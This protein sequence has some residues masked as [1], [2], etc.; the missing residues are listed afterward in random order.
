MILFKFILS[1]SLLIN[2][3]SVESDGFIESFEIKFKLIVFVYVN[4]LIF[5]FRDF[6][7][8]WKNISLFIGVYYFVNG[9]V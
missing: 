9:G 5:I 3:K 8:F 1:L 2:D 4:E 7:I 6:L